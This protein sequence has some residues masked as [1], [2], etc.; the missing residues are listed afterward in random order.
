MNSTRLR[1]VVALAW[2]L[3]AWAGRGLAQEASGTVAASVDGDPIGDYFAHWFDRV[4]AAKASQ[5]QWMTPLATVT[6]RLE[7]E[8]RYDQYWERMGNGAA[9]TNFDA[10]K[11]LE[12]IPSDS[13][14]VLINLPPDEERRRRKPASGFGDWPVLTVKQRFVGADEAH[15]NYVVSG[16]LGVQ[17]P[18]GSSA[19]SNHAWMITPTLAAGKGWG[20]FDIQ[21]TVGAPIPLAHER[22]I[23]TALVTNV[24]LQ[25]HLGRYL[26]PELEANATYWADGPRGG[27]TQVFLT[28]GLILGRFPLAGR[29]KIIIGVGY[30]F[31]VSPR[32][33]T[34]PVLTPTYQESWILTARTTF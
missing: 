34:T 20:A 26:W 17:A 16:F 32:L 29:S 15:G 8:F 14:E 3:T 1:A 19:F 18:I 30:Q 13:N 28:P 27:K 31:A 9:L 12:L 5:P 10:G 24:A 6:P 25:Q 22:E 23:G 4:D 2:L 33:T 7:E 11:G 21:V